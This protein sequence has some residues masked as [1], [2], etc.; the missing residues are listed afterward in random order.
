MPRLKPYWVNPVEKI[1]Y[2]PARHVRQ[3]VR[4]RI[5]FMEEFYFDALA[6]G[7]MLG[8]RVDIHDVNLNNPT[9]L[10]MDLTR[11]PVRRPR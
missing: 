3:V 4:W 6:K 7:R 11:L 9:E 5:P 8:F 1:V 10:I 2:T